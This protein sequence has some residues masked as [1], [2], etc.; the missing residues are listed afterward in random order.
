MIKSTKKLNSANRSLKIAQSHKLYTFLF[1]LFWCAFF[2]VMQV[3]WNQRI[4]QLHTYIYKYIHIYSI[5]IYMYVNIYIA[6]TR[7]YSTSLLEISSKW[8]FQMLLY[9]LKMCHVAT[10]RPVLIHGLYS[11]QSL[12]PKILVEKLQREKKE[13][14]KW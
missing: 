8:Y 14:K 2:S 7:Q 3:H 4:F 11:V 9:L 13:R 6:I 1:Y 12:F 5:Y 10:C